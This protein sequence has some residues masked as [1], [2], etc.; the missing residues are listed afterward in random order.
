MVFDDA[1][2]KVTVAMLRQA[3][4]MCGRR[5]R[6]EHENRRSNKLAS[7]RFRV[8]NQLTEHARLAQLEL[9]PPLKAA[10]CPLGLEPEERRV[11][12]HAA[13]TYLRLFGARD[14]RSVDLD[15]WETSVP[16]LGIRLVGNGGLPFED[17]QGALELRF[18]S[19]GQRRAGPVDPVRSAESR[20]ALLRNAEW[21]AG[22]QVRLV[23]ADL[24]FGEL[25]EEVVEIDNELDELRL[26]LDERVAIVRDRIRD[27]TPHVGLECGRCRFVAG[28][29]AHG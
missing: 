8:S 16:E 24:L 11:Y 20:F 26:W 19:L 9:G 25:V 13:A 14:A 5:L 27:A 7:G 23:H 15:E 3:G 18:C 22:S 17:A 10:F 2:P 29:P 6:F 4:T 1:L 21:A 12:D 28:C